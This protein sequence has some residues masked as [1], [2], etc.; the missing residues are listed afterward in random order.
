MDEDEQAERITPGHQFLRENQAG[1]A[2]KYDTETRM[3]SWFAVPGRPYR[4]PGGWGLKSA[5]GF[6]KVRRQKVLTEVIKLLESGWS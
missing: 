5:D 4:D 6:E 3:G 1:A 2:Q